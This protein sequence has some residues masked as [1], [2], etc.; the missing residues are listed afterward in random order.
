MNTVAAIPSGPNP[1]YPD[2][3]NNCSIRLFPIGTLKTGQV[4]NIRNI[5]EWLKKILTF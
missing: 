3:R 5:L 1:I 4:T 2:S